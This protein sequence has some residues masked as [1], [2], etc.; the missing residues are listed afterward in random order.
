MPSLPI[1]TRDAEAGKT[2]VRTLRHFHF[3][4]PEAAARLAPVGGDCLPALL[5]PFRDSSRLRYEYPL[6]LRA[7][8]AAGEESGAQPLAQPLSEYLAA[9]AAAVGDAG[10]ARLLKD[11]LPWVE[12]EVRQRL[13][14]QEGPVAARPL[15][16]AAADAL[17]AHLALG[18]EDGARLREGLNGLLAA[19]PESGRLLG[20]G[21]YPAIHLLIHAIR[22]VTGPRH[23]R[24]RGE[25]EARIRDLT[26]LLEVERN[27]SIEAIEPARLRDAV[28][29]AGAWLNPLALSDVMDHSMGSLA[30]APGRKR[31]IEEA[32][33]ALR[34]FRD[35]PVG[36]RIVYRGRLKNEEWLRQVPGFEAVCVDDPCAAAMEVFDRE[37]ARLAKVFTAARIADLELAD[38]YDPAIHDPWFAGFGW[39]AFSKEELLLVPAVIALE[40]ATRMAGEGMPSFSRLLGSGRPVQVCVRVRAHTNPGSATREDPLCTYRTELGYLAIA[41]RQTYVAQSSAA[42]PGHLVHGYLEALAAARTSVHLINTGLRP[43]AVDT[44]LNAWLVAGAA[45]EGRV[46]PFFRVNPGKGDSAAERFDFDGNPQPEKDWAGHPFHY[47]DESGVAVERELPFTY[48]DYGLL[49]EELRAH[50]ALVPPECESDDLVPVSDYLAAGDEA[51]SQR[52][53]FVWAVDGNGTLHRVVISRALVHACRDRLNF[54]HALQEMAGVKNRHVELAVA[55]ARAEAWAMADAEIARLT[56]EHAQELERVRAAAAGEVMGRLTEVLMGMDLSHGGPR[57]A[58]ARAP[59]RPAAAPAT[60]PAA[61]AAGPVAAAVVVVAAEESGGCDEPWIDTALCSSCNDCM[62]INPRA[63]AYNDEKQ[64]YITDP[65]AATYAELVQAAEVCPSR[66]IHPGQPMDPAEPGLAELRLRAAAFN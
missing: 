20:Y 24:F 10:A 12:R 15:L 33:A 6:F 54:W 64:A 42:R 47:Q 36:V 66:C 22:H 61:V 19:V 59:V 56:A 5:E 8:D 1:T 57:L 62:T 65:R 2:I 11:N 60:E 41:H 44:S 23:A 4:N 43:R 14:G 45:L 26:R 40:S 3:G 55:A 28:G 51:A 52:V 58:A 48:A 53:P 37:A 9:G 29:P 16:A 18:A 30:M 63:F 13:E 35:A 46:H 34:A 17:V 39:E 38:I 21:R 49:I 50:Y 31:R 7:A 27:K 32:L 25:V